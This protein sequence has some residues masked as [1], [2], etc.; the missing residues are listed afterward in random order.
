MPLV[1]LINGQRTVSIDISQSK[2]IESVKEHRDGDL[3]IIMPCC[4]AH[5]HMR[6]SPKGLQHFY[7]AIT[8]ENWEPESIEH[9]EAKAEIYKVCKDA[10]WIVDIEVLGN[11]WRA[12]ILATNGHLTIAFEVQLSKISEEELQ[13]RAAAYTNQNIISHWIFSLP[14][15]YEWLSGILYREAYGLNYFY[16][17]LDR[18]N[19]F[20]ENRIIDINNAIFFK[21]LDK[22]L[23]EAEAQDWKL[24]PIDCHVPSPHH[25]LFQEHH[26]SHERHTKFCKI[27][28]LIPDWMYPPRSKPSKHSD[29]YNAGNR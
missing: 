11:G 23:A 20:Y 2:W 5:G 19:E 9:L 12:D 24:S 21:T 15:D 1:A 13:R 18:I 25:G 6:I 4:G 27:G 10:G 29:E 8:C 16:D 17:L 22:D 26:C 14:I 7:H 3:N 28:T